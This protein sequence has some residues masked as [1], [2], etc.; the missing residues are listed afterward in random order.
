MKNDK[1]AFD[2][3]V[4]PSNQNVGDERNIEFIKF[5]DLQLKDLTLYHIEEIT[6]EEKS[7][8]KK[9]L[10]NIINSINIDGVNF[11]YLIIGDKKGVHFYFGVVKDL[12]KDRVLDLEISDIGEFVLKPSIKGNF[13]GIVINEVKV[14]D[15]ENLLKKIQTMNNYSILDGVPGINKDN[16]EFQGVDRLVDV[17]LGDEFGLMVIAKPLDKDEIL[18]IEKNLYHL[19]D[20]IAPL[21]NITVTEATN[22]GVVATKSKTSGISGTKGDNYSKNDTDGSGES[23]SKSKGTS[24]GTDI[25]TTQTTNSGI[26]SKGDSNIRTEGSSKSITTES[27]TSRSRSITDGTSNTIGIDYSETDGTATNSGTSIS[28]T[29]TFVNKEAQD[30]LKYLDEVIMPRLDYG[31]GN[32]LF[33]STALLFTKR[34][35]SLI[36]LQ[37]TIKSLNFGESGNKVPLKIN[38]VKDCIRLDSLK[39]FQLP[40]GKSKLKFSKNELHARAGLSQFAN[41]RSEIYIGNWV[42]TRE[43]TL[44]AGL[45]NKEV[46]GLSLREEIEFGLDFSNEC[47]DKIYLGKLVQSGTTMEKIDV[48]IDKDNLYNHVFITGAKGS[49]KTVTWQNL[50]IDSD[51]PFLII[52]PAKTE[53][54]ILT[55]KYP[56]L[57]IFKLGMQNVAPFRL[58]PFE[59]FKHESITSRVDMIKASIQVAFDMEATILQIIEDA[60][61]KCYEDYGWNLATNKN[62]NNKDP[63]ADGVYAFPTLSDLIKKTEVVVNEL[64]FDERLKNH[65]IGSIKAR[66]QGLI[67]GCKGLMLNSKRSI[68]FE[69][70]IEKPV[71]LEVLDIRN[72]GEKSL[73]MG[74][75]LTSLREVVKA[76]YLKQGVFKH[77]TVIDEAHRIF[78]KCL[79]GESLDKKLGIEMFTDILGEVGK[80]GEALIIVDRMI[81]K[82]SEEVLRNTNTKIVPY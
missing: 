64:I 80:Y 16:E 38:N 75:I 79:I 3:V 1:F 56:D 60:L 48:C 24:R 34:K 54:R 73:I 31:K 6:F 55:K 51:L 61:Y 28:E 49:G 21:S 42:S 30:W 77:I 58:N 40:Y 43:L 41:L 12:Y 8:R 52:E 53:Y 44:L 11:I 47:E 57:L 25:I 27:N 15:K 26:L 32:G 69:Y 36:K 17:M 59:F 20:S 2:F 82:L 7:P 10:E 66:L 35:S 29:V 33:I 46:S 5:Q 14:E 71:V 67:I 39:N 72:A 76:K 13:R 4:D 78:C 37:S 9:A 70:L 68:N 62:E 63:F 23:D 18:E 81:D 19:Y 50:L 74:F 22:K 45:P 65:Y